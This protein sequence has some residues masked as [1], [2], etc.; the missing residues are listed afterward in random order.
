MKH[1]LVKSII[2]NETRAIIGF[3]LMKGLFKNVALDRNNVAYVK[4]DRSGF[5]K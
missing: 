4:D 2:G 1:V 3:P 5:D